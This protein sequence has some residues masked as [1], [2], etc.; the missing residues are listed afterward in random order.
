LSPPTT[1]TNV[2]GLFQ[3]NDGSISIVLPMTGAQ[4]FY[5]LVNP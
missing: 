5:R 2:T 3:I 4:K 1:W